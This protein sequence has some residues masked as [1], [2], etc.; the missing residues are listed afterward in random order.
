MSLVNWLFERTE[1]LLEL[2]CTK[3]SALA[4]ARKSFYTESDPY[5]TRFYLTKR[6][7]KRYGLYLHYHH[8]GEPDIAM[9]SHPYGW[10]VS[11]VLTNGYVEERWDAETKSMGVREL[12]PGSMSLIRADDFHRIQLSDPRRGAWTLFL[13]GRR[14]REEWGFWWPNGFNR[15]V[16]HF[17]FTRSRLRYAR[18]N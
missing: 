9:H 10:C 7:L 1:P 2:A 18:P 13:A 3:F 17:N 8:R 14:V 15:F 5:L 4:L 16:P 6:S 11:V 12:R